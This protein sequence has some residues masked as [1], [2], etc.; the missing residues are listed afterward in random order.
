MISASKSNNISNNKYLTINQI[1]HGDSTEMLKSI[2]PDS[3]ALSFWSPPYHVGKEYEKEQTFDDWLYLLKTV[4]R[5]HFDILKPGSFLVVNIDDILAFPDES[6]P[7]FQALNKSKLKC[8]VTKEQILDAMERYPNYNRY[9]LAKLLGCSE[10][11]VDRRLNGNNIRG[12]KYNTQTKVKLVGGF[13]ED[14]AKEAGLYLY[15][16]RIWVKDPTWTNSQ[17]H[18]NSYR[19]VSE[20]EYLYCF[21]KPGITLV[22]RD[23]LTKAEWSEWGS[24]GVWFIPSV[25]KNN[26]HEA[27]FPIELAQRVIR[28]Y[29]QVDDTVL[30]CFMGSGT[31]AIAS[32]LERRNFI[33]VEKESKYVNLAKKN[34]ANCSLQMKLL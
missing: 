14:Y 11:T 33:G 34:V 1:Y 13:L 9:Q 32:I 2:E 27:K 30:D 10:Q 5:L 6:M 15:D 31:T 28:L 4:I 3:I 21:W 29:T 20:F 17:W 16:R 26:D 7:K 19:S 12:G 24:R 22:E 8:T 25:R 18:S 23:K